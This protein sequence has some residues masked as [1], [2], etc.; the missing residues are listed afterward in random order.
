MRCLTHTAC[1]VRSYADAIY[2]TRDPDNK[3]VIAGSYTKPAFK[4]ELEGLGRFLTFPEASES[5]YTDLNDRDSP[6][7]EVLRTRKPVFLRDVADKGEDRL[8]LRREVARDY[9]IES[10]AFVPILG[11]VIEIGTSRGPSTRQWA[12][13]GDALQEQIPN[14]AIE[15]AFV[16]EGA[17]YC[18]FWSRNFSSGACESTPAP[19]PPTGTPTRA[20]QEGPL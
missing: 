4:A 14:A 19:P 8:R 11:G 7:A 1:T 2:W 20:P 5:F 9:N 12:S 15:T 17:T 3:A 18:I 10:I 6:V 16:K 13:L